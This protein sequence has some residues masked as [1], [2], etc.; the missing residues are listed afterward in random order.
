MRRP[1]SLSILVA[2]SAS[3]AHADIPELAGGLAASS[4]GL[5]P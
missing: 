4:R 2:L 5:T 3:L 1:L